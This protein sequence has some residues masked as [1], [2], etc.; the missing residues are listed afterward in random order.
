MVRNSRMGPPTAW[1][2]FS[3]ITRCRYKPASQNL[4][5]LNISGKT[6][7]EFL[8]PP[9]RTPGAEGHGGT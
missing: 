9:F 5:D 7:A 2:N 1:S 6:V 4:T 3:L 8:F